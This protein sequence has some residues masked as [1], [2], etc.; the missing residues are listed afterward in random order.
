MT[1]RPCW[2]GIRVGSMGSSAK[3]LRQISCWTS[4]LVSAVLLPVAIGC[5]P[6]KS[7][8]PLAARSIPMDQVYTSERLA[9]SQ[10]QIQCGKRRPIID[11]IGWVV[12][13]PG[14]ILLWDR[15]VEN[16]RISVETH[17]FVTEYLARNDMGDVRVRLNQ[18]HP[19]DDWRRLVRN[20]S[21]AAPWRYTLGTLSV[22]GETLLPGRIFGGDHY[23]PYTD[24]IHIYSDI[25]AIALHEAAHAKDFARRRWKGTYA[26]AY[27][28][29]VVPLYHES[30]ASSDVIAY[31]EVFG[32]PEQQAEA[33][34][35]LHPSY[36]TYVGS[37]AGAFFPSI[38]GPLYYGSLLA[39]HV[40]GR[41]QARQLLARQANNVQFQLSS[42]PINPGSMD[43]SSIADPPRSQSLFD[44]LIGSIFS[45]D[46]PTTDGDWP[47]SSADRLGL[48]E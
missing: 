9:D 1:V 16:H 13:I 30:V 37:A 43:S 33:A 47:E 19:K 41:Y 23:N 34:R 27:T 26:A 7:R 28:L 48:I 44:P 6:L 3:S 42:A 45:A 29:P 39:G 35:I 2:E 14:K 31:L 18:Y 10:P 15:R 21:V 12:G 4:L 8:M 20:D 24:T 32:T 11:G 36:G 25:P 38:G 22:L 40:T 5:A 46:L 17:D